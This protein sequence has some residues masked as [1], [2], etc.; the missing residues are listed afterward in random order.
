MLVSQKLHKLAELYE[1]VTFVKI[2]G[3]SPEWQPFC[4][5][6]ALPGVPWFWFYRGGKIVAS[7]SMSLNPEKLAAFRMEI[8]RHRHASA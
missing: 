3:S 8:H 6:A 2:N 4:Q 1:D 7:L 5:E